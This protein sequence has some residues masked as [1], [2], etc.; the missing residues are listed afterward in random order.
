MLISDD[1][2]NLSA[3]R[4]TGTGNRASFML[5]S[6]FFWPVILINQIRSL[7]L[8]DSRFKSL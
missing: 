8:F 2:L 6:V 5:V 3:A 4:G 1:V 7:K